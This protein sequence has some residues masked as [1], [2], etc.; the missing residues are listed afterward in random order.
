MALWIN[1]EEIIAEIEK[2][3]PC[4]IGEFRKLSADY[5]RCKKYGSYD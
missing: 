5:R 1:K 4:L 2:C 3:V